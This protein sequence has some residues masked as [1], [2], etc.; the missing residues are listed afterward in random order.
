[1]LLLLLVLLHQQTI[2]I[3]FLILTYCTFKLIA[4]LL[5]TRRYVSLVPRHG[6]LRPS[7]QGGCSEEGGAGRSDAQAERDDGGSQREESRSAAGERV[8]RMHTEEYVGCI[9]KSMSDT[10]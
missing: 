5:H 6:H 7:G 1:M 8:C 3:L 9:L 2:N 10:Y 4:I